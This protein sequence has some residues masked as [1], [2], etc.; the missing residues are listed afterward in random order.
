MT[1]V[2]LTA[3]NPE[4]SSVVPVACNAKGELKLEEVPTFDGNV[5]GDLT[6][7]GSATFSKSVYVNDTDGSGFINY[8]NASENSY[9]NLGPAKG[10][11]GVVLGLKVD[12]T[13][14]DRIVYAFDKDNSLAPPT[15][16]INAN[17]SA[18]FASNIKATRFDIPAGT[19]SSSGSDN[20]IY[21]GG[22][23]LNGTWYDL[24]AFNP[25]DSS[26]PWGIK[27]D[28]SCNFAGNKAGFTAE[29]YLWCTTRR[30]DTVILDFTSN[31]MAT[32]A[33]YTP[34]RISDLKDKWSEK[35]VIRPVPEE[36]SQDEPETPQ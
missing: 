9:I 28:G 14:T 19:W 33:P 5:D 36:S 32:W 22:S 35:D 21:L 7:S 30:G 23:Q 15:V 4:D 29:G 24:S 26:V 1:D 16:S 12:T 11:A 13:S 27:P 18:T 8:A 3:T 31:G 17:G 10:T 34:T 2:R 20:G 6:V 25:N